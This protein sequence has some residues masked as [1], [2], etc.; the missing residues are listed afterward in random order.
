MLN[1][2]TYIGGGNGSDGALAISSGTTT[3]SITGNYLEKNYSS[4]SISGTALLN[5]SG[6]TGSGAVIY[7][8]CSGDF[9]M[10]AGTIDASGMGG[11]G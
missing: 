6:N 3:L 11:I 2:N 1:A 5:F 8:K 7:I 4:I 10:T 9:T